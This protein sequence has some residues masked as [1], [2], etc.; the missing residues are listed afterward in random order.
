[1]PDIS[2]SEAASPQEV[3]KTENGAVSLQKIQQ[4]EA[5]T[6]LQPSFAPKMM[7]LEKFL[8]PFDKSI[9]SDNDAGEKYSS[10]VASFIKEQLSDQFE[11]HKKSAWFRDKYHPDYMRPV[12][13]RSKAI[14]HR[15]QIFSDMLQHGFLDDVHLEFKNRVKI[16]KVLDQC[17]FLLFLF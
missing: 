6:F 15:F 1:M 8:E 14:E 3:G 13:D 10:Y 17:K 4:D 7:S 16:T 12:E 2:G 9:L 11:R 5:T